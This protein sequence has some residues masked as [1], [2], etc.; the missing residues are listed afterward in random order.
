MTVQQHKQSPQKNQPAGR[1][2]QPTARQSAP[3]QAVPDV[4]RALQDPTQASPA[5]ILQLQQA[6]GNRAVSGLIQ[7]SLI[8]ASL[9]VG[10]AG[11]A[12][13]QEADRV[14]AQ[15]MSPT[16][17]TPAVQRLGEEEE[18]LQ[19]K[20]LAASITP[21]VQRAALPEE[22]ELQARPLLQRQAVEEEEELQA[23]PAEDGGAFAPSADFESRL[24]AARG[25]GSPMPDPTRDFMEQRFGA[26]FGGVRLHTGSEPTRLNQDI[27]AQAFTQGQDIY[28]GEG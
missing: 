21:L 5:E 18:E 23:K 13:E 1:G 15:V 17:S 12:Y 3:P 8:Q 24:A 26:D 4:Q 25:S 19:A 10:P 28:L 14:A 11:D 2:R 9:R 6:A 22:E 7:A 27:N 20:P 16:A